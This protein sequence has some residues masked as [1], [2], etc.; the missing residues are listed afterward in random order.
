MERR[1]NKKIENYISDFKDKVKERAT[2]LGLTTDTNISQLVQYIYDY[3]R[4][5]LN[6]EDFMKRKRVKNVVH[7]SDRCCATRANEEQCTRRR[8]DDTTEYCGTHLKG[9]PHGVCNFEEDVK[10]QGHKTEVWLQDIQGI[11]YYIDKTFNV[12]QPEDIMSGKVNP[13]V[14]AKYVKVGEFYSIPEFNL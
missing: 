2:E 10:P 13:K 9:T 8:K 6:K 11:V 3:E 1:I 5:T 14:I 4:L 12:Y 7:L